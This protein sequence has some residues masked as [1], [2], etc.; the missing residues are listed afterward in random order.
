MLVDYSRQEEFDG[1]FESSNSMYKAEF[2]HHAIIGCGG[3]GFWLGIML[4][5]QGYDNIF[6]VD[7]QK[8][9]PSNLN[10]IPV[11]P[12]WSGINKTVALRRVIKTVRPLCKVHIMPSH[13]DKDDLDILGRF[14]NNN[15]TWVIWDC[16]DDARVQRKIYEWKNK[17]SSV[18]Y[19]KIGYEGFNVGTYTN[20]DV[21]TTESYQPGYRT[22]NACAATSALAAVIGLFAQ[23]LDLNNDINLNIENILTQVNKGNKMV[24]VAPV[25]TKEP[26]EAAVPI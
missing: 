18:F 22:S 16:T 2:P 15:N 26:T 23:G 13:V 7:G 14:I 8:L 19:R 25:E 4:A 9:E 10:R 11:S 1:V 3:V 6:L 20:Y 24:R 17:F 5:M 12:S 21:W